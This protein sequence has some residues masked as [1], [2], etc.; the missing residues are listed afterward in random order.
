MVSIWH[1]TDRC[2]LWQ[3]QGNH[4]TAKPVIGT[5]PQTKRA[6]HL[7]RNRCGPRRDRWSAN[8]GRNVE[9]EWIS[10]F[11]FFFF[12][13][14]MNSSANTIIWMDAV[15]WQLQGSYFTANSGISTA[16][17]TKIAFDALGNRHGPRPNRWSAHLGRNVEKEYIYIF[18]GLNSSPKTI[19]QLDSS[20]GSRRGA[21]LQQNLQS[22]HRPKIKESLTRYQFGVGLDPIHAVHT[23]AGMW[24]KNKF[25]IFSGIG[26]VS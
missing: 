12:F 23:L 6:L 21:I 22:A 19:K 3:P 8:L 2:K 13:F 10:I 20:F 5:P 15:F 7:L 1:K 17:Q 24:K 11:F 16:P 25:P 18:F 9:N 26:F 4:F 14:G